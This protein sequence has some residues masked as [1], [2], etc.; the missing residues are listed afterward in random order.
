MEDKKV[1]TYTTVYKGRDLITITSEFGGGTTSA[2]RHF[3]L[4]KSH[5]EDE[6]TKIVRH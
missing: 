4:Y 3:E 1:I 2:E 6:N 5:V